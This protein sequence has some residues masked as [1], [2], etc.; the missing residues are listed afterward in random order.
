MSKK[1]NN[2]LKP[3]DYN[4][5]DDYNEYERSVIAANASRR[6]PFIGN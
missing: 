5:I 2:K 3:E 6:M 1:K 4:T